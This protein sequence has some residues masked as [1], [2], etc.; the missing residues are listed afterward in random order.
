MSRR[1]P[2]DDQSSVAGWIS[3]MNSLKHP[4]RHALLVALSL[5]VCGILNPALAQTE[6]PLDPPKL[7]SLG[8]PG[9]AIP[10]NTWLFSPTLTIATFFDSNLY[11]SPTAPISAGG[12]KVNPGLV[13]IWTNGIHTTTLYGNIDRKIYPSAHENNTFDRQAGVIQRYEALR[14]LIFIVQGDYSHKTIFSAL[15]NAIPGPITTPVAPGTPPP[16]PSGSISVPSNSIAINPSD[17]FTGTASVEK[18]FNRAYLKFSASYSRTKYENQTLAPDFGVATY[19]GSGGIWLGPAVFAYA[20]GSEAI[21]AMARAYQ[22]VTGLGTAQL[23]LFRASVYVGRQGSEVVDS[24]TAGGPIYG[25][26]LSYYPTRQWTIVASVDETINNSNQTTS[27]LALNT[28]SGSTSSLSALAVPTSAST[29]MTAT[30]LKSDYVISE[31]VSTYAAL[32][33]TRVEYIDTFERDNSWLFDVG[34]IYKIRRDMALTLNYQHSQI[35]S[36]APNVS[37]VREY[38]I[39]GAKFGF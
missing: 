24:G 3:A 22:A 30:A 25:G 20:E 1:H 31:T 34:I 6:P 28:T 38:V 33:Y 37:S 2:P 10:L 4:R 12:F 8:S 14:D 27:S 18:Q 9:N 39:L 35:V 13:A 11:Q 23:G 26:K 32:G 16:P 5:F 29:R 17:Q 7:I 15:Q 19:T 21:H 36:N